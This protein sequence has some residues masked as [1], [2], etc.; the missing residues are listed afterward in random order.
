MVGSVEPVVFKQFEVELQSTAYSECDWAADVSDGKSS[1]SYILLLNSKA[2]RWKDYKQKRSAGSSTE[3]KYIALS[4]CIR[5]LRYFKNVLSERSI[6]NV[7]AV[8]YEDK[9]E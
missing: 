9:Q 1:C 6:H 7:R 3:A 2:V 8:V 4:G 5:E